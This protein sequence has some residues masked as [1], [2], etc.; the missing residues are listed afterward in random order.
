MK[1]PPLDLQKQYKT[2]KKEIR[3]KI[4]AVC[5]AQAFVLGKTVSDF[6]ERFAAYCGAEYA[7]GC[8]NGTDA[9]LLSLMVAGIT[10]GDEVLVPSFTFIASSEPVARVGATPVFCDIDPE[11]YNIDPFLLEEKITPNTKAIIVVHLYGQTVHM[12]PI[13]KL[14]RKYH[15]TVIE[16]ACQAVGALYG[17]SGEKAGTFGDLAAFSFFPTKNLG[18]FGD[19]GMLVTGNKRYDEKLRMMRQH[20]SKKRYH[21]DILGM[22]SRLDALQ[23]A[24]LDV[25]LD[26]LDRW[27]DARRDRAQRYTKLLSERFGP[28]VMTPLTEKNNIH[29]FHQYTIQINGVSGKKRDLLLDIL[30]AHD[31]GAM[32]YYPIPC[33]LQKCFSYLGYSKGSLPVTEAA[34]QRVFSLPL[35]PELTLKQQAYVVETIAYGLENI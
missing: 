28:E 2:L 21:N 31:I 6:E 19:G 4:D 7:I 10:C 20:G 14:A 32:T 5:E 26:F 34:S 17:V 9:I 25:K 11:T 16:D 15:L 22:N 23:A 1:V 13:L 12:K 18:G 33:H 35:Y 24:V 29:T 27:L 3:K 8:A 30:H